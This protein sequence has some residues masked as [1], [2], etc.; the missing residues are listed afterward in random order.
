MSHL[1]RT[2][3]YFLRRKC[4]FSSEEMAFPFG[5]K[6]VNIR[7][8]WPICTYVLADANYCVA[9]YGRMCKETG[10]FCPDFGLFSVILWNFSWLFSNYYFVSVFYGLM[11]SF[12]RICL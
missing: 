10:R 7:R 5:G 11:L 4:R 2:K 3:I 12:E 6:S 8:R 9:S 1:V